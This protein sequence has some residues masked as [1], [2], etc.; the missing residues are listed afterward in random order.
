MSKGM[1]SVYDNVKKCDS[2][3]KAMPW[4]AAVGKP[5][6]SFSFDE[7]FRLDS[8]YSKKGDQMLQDEESWSP[9]AMGA[10]VTI[11]DRVSPLKVM[12]HI[13]SCSS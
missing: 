2:P 9:M 12:Q 4:E 3:V 1:I 13:G 10:Q 7:N 6:N 11:E 5:C 8:D